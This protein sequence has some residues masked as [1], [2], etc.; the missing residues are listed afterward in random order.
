MTLRFNPQTEVPEDVIIAT[1]SHVE[2][3]ANYLFSRYN[4]ILPPYVGRDDLKSDGIFGLLNAA[5]KYE[6]GRGV[7][8]KTYADSRIRG[9]IMDEIR[10]Q[11]WI[12]R[13]DQRK[14]KEVNKVQTALRGLGREPTSEEIANYLGNPVQEIEA[15]LGNK[16]KKITYLDR[17]IN[18]EGATFGEM[19]VVDTGK[20]PEEIAIE[21]ST[22]E[23]LYNALYNAIDELPEREKQVIIQYYNEGMKLKEIGKR[24]GV[25]KDRASQIHT[26]AI[27]TLRGKLE[28]LK[29]DLF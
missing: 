6:P 28:P 17:P 5:G 9:N 11:S 12:S 21:K 3:I 7:K 2:K 8:F 19:Y 27:R 26:K 15:T 13:R 23:M 22:K 16:K 29:Q 1:L 20:T 18:G 24:L 10:N 25:S 14:I 4:K